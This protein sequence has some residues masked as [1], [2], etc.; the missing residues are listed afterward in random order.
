MAFRSIKHTRL[1]VLSF[2]NQ[3]ELVKYVN[4]LTFKIEIKEISKDGSRW[5]LFFVLPENPTIDVPSG[6]L[7]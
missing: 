7:N 1:R 2:K 3:I 5:H 4:S 6:D